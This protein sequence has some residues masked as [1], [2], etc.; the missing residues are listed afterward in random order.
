MLFPVHFVSSSAL[1][2]DE[3]APTTS[4]IDLVFHR[5]GGAGKTSLLCDVVYKPVGE[6]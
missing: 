5:A 3:D 6:A 4:L 2:T 1:R